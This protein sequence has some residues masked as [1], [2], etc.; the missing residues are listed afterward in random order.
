MVNQKETFEKEDNDVRKKGET[1]EEKK[2][3]EWRLKQTK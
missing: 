1:L 3:E 2:K